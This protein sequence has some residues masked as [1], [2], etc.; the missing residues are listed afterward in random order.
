MIL[1]QAIP[2]RVRGTMDSSFRRIR[3]SNVSNDM[4]QS[5]CRR[6]FDSNQL[7]IKMNSDIRKS[8]RPLH[9]VRFMRMRIKKTKTLDIF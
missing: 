2:L 5:Y 7:S 9:G 8:L 4:I 1:N 6:V 3:F